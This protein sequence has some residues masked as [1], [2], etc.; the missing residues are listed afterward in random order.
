MPEE[1]FI[2]V[3]PKEIRIAILE[4]KILQEIIVERNFRQSEIGNIYKGRVTRVV[5]GIQAAFIDIGEERAA[6]LHVSD[7]SDQAKDIRDVVQVGQDLFVQVY[8]DPLG[9]K[10]PRVTT[11]FTLPSR[12]LVFTPGNFEI[13]ISQKITDEKERARMLALL[14]SSQVGGYIFRTVAEH[15]AESEILKDQQYLDSLWQEISE[16]MR[17]AKT[18][19]RVYVEPSILLRVL[20][21]H[22]GC[23]VE[24]I[25]VDN[26][27]AA[28]QMKDFA[29]K[30]LP[31]FTDRI[32]FYA[33]ERPLFDIF[34]VEKELQEA[35][36][37]KVN[38]KS[39]GYIVFDQ[40]EAMTTIDVNTGSFLGR[41][42]LEQT[43]FKT[44]LEAVETIARQ[45]R[46]RNIGGII[47]IDFIDM[48]EETHK[49]AVLQA[50]SS[51]L[52]K[53]PVRTEISELSRLGLVQMTRKRDRES[54]ERT[55]CISCPTCRRRG[56]IKSLTTMGYEIIRELKRS[57]QLFDWPGFLVRAASP[58]IEYLK[59]EESA[60]LEELTTKWNKPIELKVETSYG[61]EQ[62][63]VLPGQNK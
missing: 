30:Y 51:A 23:D 58:V 16:R 61:Q 13:N 15:I 42:N 5:P 26:E 57:N 44:N 33:E 8:K 60:L 40:T 28:T 3:L 24:R 21:D 53:D 12:Y 41:D 37:P 9:T 56:S 18:G 22:A 47:I 20:R 39:G 17:S 25:R 1:F 48:Q 45:L 59:A 19:E 27:M 49:T 2:N 7:V 62:F 36:E 14:K 52:E 11:Q 63:D 31:F 35:L 34:S 55:L 50:L 10:G 54:L 38:L 43:I 29:K 6:F 32:E 4:N 46:L